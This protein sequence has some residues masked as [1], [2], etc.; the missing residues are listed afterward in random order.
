MA[1]TPRRQHVALQ[2]ATGKWTTFAYVRRNSWASVVFPTPFGPA[3][4]MQ[5]GA[6]FRRVR[7]FRALTIAHRSRRVFRTLVLFSKTARKN[8]NP[9][10]ERKVSGCS[11]VREP[12]ALV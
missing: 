9:A 10:S 4:M 1:T 5:R 12:N 3:M 6:F 7:F 2:V 8:R 11:F